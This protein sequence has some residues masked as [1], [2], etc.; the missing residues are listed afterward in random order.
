MD[1]S[2]PATLEAF[3]S[4]AQLLRIVAQGITYDYVHLGNLRMINYAIWQGGVLQGLTGVI[5]TLPAST[6]SQITACARPATV[7]RIP[8]RAAQKVER[9]LR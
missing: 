2:D 8:V 5:K 6:P 9:R 3:A 1:F 4:Y 7:K